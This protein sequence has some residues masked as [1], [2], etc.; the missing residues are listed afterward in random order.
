MPATEQTWRNLKAMHVVFG[1]SAI[2][3]LVTTV[4]ML[5]ADHNREWKDYQRKFQDVETWTAES[6]I[7]EQKTGEFEKEDQALD[8]A[9]QAERA[10]APN[11]DLVALFVERAKPLANVNGYDIQAVERDESEIASTAPGTKEMIN[12]RHKLLDD[13]Q[14]LIKKARFVEDRKSGEL[15]FERANLDVVRSQYSIAVDQERSEA[16]QARVEQHVEQ[17][18][19]RVEDMALSAQSAKTHRLELEAIYGKIVADEAAALKALNDHAGALKRLQ[20]AYEERRPNFGKR[21][22]EMPIIDAFGRPLKVDNLWLPQLTFNNNFRDVARFDRCTTCHQGIEKTAPGSAVE[23]GYEP[24]RRVVVK[25]ATPKEP[26]ATGASTADVYGMVLADR[27]LIDANDVTVEVVWPQTLAAQALLEAGDVIERINDVKIV[28]RSLAVRY[29]LQSVAWGK[30]LELGIR[31]GVPQPFNSHPRLDLFVGSLSPHKLGDVGCTICHEGQGSAT[32]FKWASHTPNTPSEADVWS[33]KHGW[34]NNHHWIYPMMP[35]RFAESTC[36]K[37]HHEVTELEASERFPDPPAPKVVEG[38][39]T[40]RQFGC[41]GCHE[42]NGWDGPKKRRGPDLRAE[43]PYFAA[44]AEILADPKLDDRMR[45]LAAEVVAHPDQTASRKQLAEMIREQ[46]SGTDAEKSA[47]AANTNKMAEIVGADDE[48]PGQFRKVGPSL[49]YVA[50]KVDLAFLVNWIRRPQ[51][52]RPNTKMPQF[53]GLWDHLTPEAKVNADGSIQRDAQGYPVMEESP[54]LR[55]SEK[56]EPIEIRAMAEYLLSASE[57]FTYLDKPAG[58]DEKPSVER[59]KLAFQT[60]GCLA[61]HRHPDFPEAKNTQGPDLARLGSKLTGTRGARWLYSWV[62]EPNRYHA[63]TVMPNVFLEPKQL[64]ASKPDSPLVDPAADITAYLLTSQGWKPGD[65]PAVDAAA[66]D[67]L[68]GKFLVGSF[69]REQTDNYVKN[70]IPA[71]RAGEL[72]GDEAVLVVDGKTSPE[73]LQKKKLLYVGR[74]SIGRLGCTGCHDVP[75]FEDA[76]PIGTG[77]ADWGRKE[78]SKLAFEQIIPYLA[79]RQH[80]ASEHPGHGDSEIAVRSAEHSAQSF[81]ADDRA[82]H[83]SSA[84]ELNHV[85]HLTSH[86]VNADAGFYIDAL[87]HHQRE[88]FIWQKLREPRSYDYKKTENKDYTERL[89]M[90]KFYFSPEQREAVISF[91]LGLVA[92]PPAARYVYKGSPRNQAIQKGQQLLAKYN[93][94]G[95]HTTRMEE[96][97]FDYKPFKQ[98]DDASFQPPPE[99][100]DYAFLKPHF[101]PAELALSKKTDRR[102]L[103]HAVVNGMPR[104]ETGED[105]EGRTLY[106][107]E[108]WKNVPIDGHAW[109]VGGQD[110]PIV[111]GTITAKRPPEG[112]D[113]ARLLHP[114]VLD[115]ERKTNPNAKPSDA[116]GWVPPP[117]V[118]EGIKVQTDWL[119]DFLLDP[120]PIR[121]AVVLRMPRFNMS[122]AEAS[123]LTNY[124][125]AVDN[126]DYPYE[127]DPRTRSEY[128]SSAEAAHPNRLREALNIMTDN[129]YCVKC[130]LI[131]DYAPS[132]AV[133]AMAPQLNRV[134]QRLRPEFLE[135]WIANPK[136]LLPYTGMP[137]NFPPD[138][139]ADQKLFKGDSRDQLEAVVDLLLNWPM[140]MDQQTSIKPMVKPPPAAAAGAE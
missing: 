80:E 132:G 32:Q 134:A 19:R 77:L 98:G 115:L 96:W 39:N 37:C 119:H 25:L 85:A 97:A 72:K 52:F 79:R 17:I 107:F 120:Y 54:G 128:L 101:T 84:E 138:K 7:R 114:V 3:M 87:L 36:L 109:A 24:I 43:P 75:G 140:Y 117:L 12:R 118:N 73:D 62:R 121:P 64:D 59:G 127:F 108:L 135:R 81:N 34:F 129:N 78:T 70:G 122:S 23:P 42:I 83:E 99:W 124:F 6:R 27:G 76:K 82:E 21:L 131:G 4:W 86:D 136:R 69:T 58:V 38:F 139:P 100:N 123:A 130:H 30:P 15:K 10:K 91:V 13:M 113:L 45:A 92:E 56:F 116:W 55:E 57:K 2:A 137:V 133:T 67:E 33:T 9:L 31:R 44:A 5:A 41:F 111:D 40:I 103:G 50:S 14:A 1:L 95:C 110:V 53:F 49:R 20:T 74:R 46:S 105:D 48:T 65:V 125:A 89:R 47:L 104:A 68:T 28:D 63:R 11:P 26:P 8:D 93:C 61:C 66:L 88:G 35:T 90:P 112:G 102:G 60:R 94:T 126:A 22:L 71:D 29:L 51:D 18:E 16:E 106:F